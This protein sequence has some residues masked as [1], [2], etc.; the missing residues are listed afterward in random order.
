MY[1]VFFIEYNVVVNISS[2]VQS[3]P[4]SIDI[5]FVYNIKCHGQDINRIYS[6]WVKHIVFLQTFKSCIINV[7][8]RILSRTF[9]PLGT[10]DI[11]A[12]G[13]LSVLILPLGLP[14]ARGLVMS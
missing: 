6:M 1:S 10:G 3:L 2:T 8:E 13:L 12:D 7:T 9:G 4:I 11:P 5:S 14:G